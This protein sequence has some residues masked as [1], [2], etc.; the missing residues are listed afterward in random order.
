M[1][2]AVV[3]RLEVVDI[4]HQHRDARVRFVERLVQALREEPAIGQ[5]GQRV[6]ESLVMEDAFQSRILNC[7]PDL[8]GE[9][10][11]QRKVV[12]GEAAHVTQAV[13]DEDGPDD[14]VVALQAR[15]HRVAYAACGQQRP[16]RLAVSFRSD[17]GGS[18]G[19]HDPLQQFVVAG[20]LDQLHHFHAF[21]PTDCRP[22]FKLA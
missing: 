9:G 8:G 22:L 4:D 15:Y 19:D 7:R 14:A 21:V 16:L 13:A 17:E 11:Q 10:F 3:D 6:V 2:H 12:A 18:V 5:V 1:T 20:F